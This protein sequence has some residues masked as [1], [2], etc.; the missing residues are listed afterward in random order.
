M[1]LIRFYSIH[2]SST[3]IKGG[4]EGRGVFPA[5]AAASRVQPSQSTPSNADTRLLHGGTTYSRLEHV[6]YPRPT[7]LR[8][9]YDTFCPKEE[10]ADILCHNPIGRR[11]RLA[12]FTTFDTSWN[13]QISSTSLTKL[14]MED[15]DCDTPPAMQTIISSENRVSI[16]TKLGLAV[17][18]P[19][20]H[21]YLALQVF[22]QYC[23]ARVCCGG[24]CVAGRNGMGSTVGREGA[25]FS[26]VGSPG[27]STKVLESNKWRISVK[28]SWR[29]QRQGA[30]SRTH[31]KYGVN[32]HCQNESFAVAHSGSGLL[33][34]SNRVGP[35]TARNTTTLDAGRLGLPPRAAR[36]IAHEELSVTLADWQQPPAGTPQR[37]SE[38]AVRSLEEGAV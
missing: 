20:I 9:R 30:G 26:Q 11:R 24:G 17:L 25:G 15:A 12:L 38:R 16:Q 32:L 2:R 1:S 5:S 10:A 8:N 27:G 21:P 33:V 37:I 3:A 29:L 23:T 28:Q 18:K 35:E 13:T 14:R 22:L 36:R 19:P 7:P 31:G 4:Q 34:Q 6:K